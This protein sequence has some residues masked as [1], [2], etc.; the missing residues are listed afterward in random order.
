ML[1][2]G[3][4]HIW[5]IALDKAPPYLALP[6]EETAWIEAAIDPIIRRRRTAGRSALR[7]VIGSY[8]G[9]DPAAL[10]FRREPGA[11]PRLAGGELAFNL[12]HADETMLLA[13]TEGREVGIDI[14]RLDRLDDDWRGVARVSFSAEE[15][16][17]LSS[18]AETM[19]LWVRKEAY[20]KALG[21]GFA[22]GFAGLTV[23]PDWTVIDLPMEAPM[24]AA[25]AFAGRDAAISYRD[26]S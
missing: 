14:D 24:A 18:G 17:A 5:R 7:A 26:F 9:R 6:P 1:D 11:K 20:T 3:A 16:G 25:L 13:V 2:H 10:R 8:L 4:I 19:R 23:G 22:Q 21:T 15:Q 12:S